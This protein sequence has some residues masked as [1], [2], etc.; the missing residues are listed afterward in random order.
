MDL[1]SSIEE[2]TTAKQPIDANIYT[3]SAG[4]S[5]VDAL[6]AG[7]LKRCADNPLG[8]SEYLILLPSR[9]ACRALREAFLRLSAGKSLLLPK[10]RPLGDIDEDELSLFMAGEND[11][12]MMLDI[13][14]SIP[15][16]RRQLLLAQ[17]IQKLYENDPTSQIDFAGAASLAAEL[18]RLLDQIYIQE[19]DFA[20]LEHLVPDKF[21]EHWQRILAFLN[22]I[23]MA[24]PAILQEEGFIDA[25]DR[26]NL[27]LKAQIKYWQKNPPKTPVIAAGST[28][29][30][31]VTSELLLC[32][33]QLPEGE[34][35]LPALDHH[36]DLATWQDMGDDHPQYHLKAVLDKADMTMADVPIWP[37]A[38]Q[39][40][41]N[42]K[43]LKLLSEVM[44]P[45]HMTEKWRH[46]S[47]DDIDET[48]LEGLSIIEAET[49]QEE[50]DIIALMMREVLEE[51]EKT[52]ALITPD[53]K[54]A[55]RVA[56]SLRRWGIEIDD[57]GGAALS[58]TLVGSWLRVTAELLLKEISPVALLACLKHP[59][60][61]LG[62]GH[63]H[64]LQQAQHLE[65][66][67]LRGMKPPKG[68]EGLRQHIAQ[69]EK[70]DEKNSYEDLYVFIDQ[71]S[72]LSDE[73]DNILRNGGGFTDMLRIHIDFAEKMAA[74]EYE[75][76]AQRLWQ[77]D[78][79]EAAAKFLHDLHS[80]S[81]DMPHIGGDEYLNLLLTLFKGQM[82]RPQYG[83]HPRLSIL[84]QLEARLY[85]TDMVILS[86]LNEGVWPAEAA[87]DPWMSR[88]MRVDFGLP[89]PE[90]A[91]S[92]AGHDFIQA[93][94]APEAIITRAKKMDGAPTIPARWLLRMETVLAAVGL[95]M[96][97]LQASHYA[98][99]VRQ[100]D[101]PQDIVPIERPAPNPP[102]AARPRKISV[103]NVEKWLCDPYEI[104]A[105]YILRLRKLDALEE[106]PSM[107]DRGT[108]IHQ[109]L[110]DF[111]RDH[112][113]RLPENAE[114]ILLQMGRD[115]FEEMALP[116][117]VTIFWWSKFENMVRSYVTAEQ[118]Y[119]HE[120]GAKPNLLESQGQ[121]QFHGAHGPFTLTAKVDRIDL[122]ADGTM[123]ILDYKTG[124]PASA[125]KVA[126]GQA[127]QLP[128][129]AVILENNG[130]SGIQNKQVSDLIYWHMCDE[131][132]KMSAIPKKTEVTDMLADAYQAMQDLID[133]FD[134]EETS[135]LCRPHA[136]WQPKYSDYTHLARIKEWG[137]MGDGDG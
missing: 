22:I 73:F 25:A 137:N 67:S 90:N 89:S 127:P 128:L 95:D 99:W 16:L 32:V 119:R 1:F 26:R 28:G 7:L 50:A 18:A 43:R 53:R 115:I 14:P 11:A 15:P 44:R 17:A 27:L 75:A 19:L 79:G 105:K 24:W 70:N 6:A 81:G 42:Q 12:E 102:I 117:D 86:G 107:A 125:T 31:P 2:E 84:G 111:M 76:G 135:Y 63:M 80:V 124:L 122:F 47:S 62:Q 87:G 77:G 38:P 96:P 134:L 55:R 85:K 3:I 23:G 8:L 40:Q 116:E 123:A 48:A 110:E 78:A 112:G 52:A 92:L 113:D 104:Y 59:Y 54:L 46:L 49:P 9:R 69:I 60:A 74:T 121:M 39:D 118:K 109:V 21:A 13:L 101:M 20:N 97:T 10:M 132:K 64:I 129:E 29:S 35:I 133:Q 103:T 51:P 68:F 65:R 30:M 136:D 94:A 83:R 131:T 108:I 36:M 4:Q 41:V 120:T 91:M 37:D 98:K 45:A 56:A 5:F 61:A 93:A 57:S 106:P 82:I 114:D 34:L 71:I 58:Q 130:F 88:Q 72:D 33:A 66:R 100:M 126:C